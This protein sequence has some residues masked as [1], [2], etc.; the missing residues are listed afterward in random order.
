MVQHALDRGYDVV[1]VCREQSV[2]KLDLEPLRVPAI[3]RSRDPGDRSLLPTRS[4]ERMSP[5]QGA[6]KTLASDRTC[7]A[8]WHG[9]GSLEMP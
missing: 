2:P 9:S 8:H 5:L 7:A 6:A 3:N 4:A 1:A